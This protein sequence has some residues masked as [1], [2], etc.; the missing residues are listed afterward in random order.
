MTDKGD[1]EC[2]EIDLCPPTEEQRSTPSLEEEP[3]EGEPRS[4]H[5]QVA[6]EAKKCAEAEARAEAKAVEEV[7]LAAEAKAAE[8]EA[9]EVMVAAEQQQKAAAKVTVKAEA[10]AK[11][12]VAA[13]TKQKVA[14]ETAP[15]PPTVERLTLTSGK[16][17]TTQKRGAQVVLT[18]ASRPSRQV[19]APSPATDCEAELSNGG[20]YLT[21]LQLA[22][23][24]VL[25]LTLTP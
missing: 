25:R 10:T 3:Y 22:A 21:P 17:G 11:R 6:T 7:R 18:A 2:E 15:A 23:R 8:A 14:V 4:A 19:A 13:K 1:E 16:R 12:M 24:A 20:V 9:V 5:E